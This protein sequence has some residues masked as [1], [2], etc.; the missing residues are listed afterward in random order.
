MALGHAALCVRSGTPI[1]RKG[2]ITRHSSALQRRY[3]SHLGAHTACALPNS[4][5]VIMLA[6]G[7]C[8]PHRKQDM[9]ELPA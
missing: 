5:R 9:V 6:R 4:L 2:G 7:R 1:P 3:F 8:L